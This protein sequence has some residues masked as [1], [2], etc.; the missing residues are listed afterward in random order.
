MIVVNMSLIYT[1]ALSHPALIGILNLCS[2]FSQQ[3][4]KFFVFHGLT[5]GLHLLFDRLY[6]EGVNLHSSVRFKK[7]GNGCNEEEA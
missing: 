6:S 7:A 4:A 5:E 2:I 1:L 3:L